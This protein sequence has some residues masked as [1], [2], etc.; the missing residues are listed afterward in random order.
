MEKKHRSIPRCRAR[1]SRWERRASGAGRRAFSE[2]ARCAAPTPEYQLGSLLY[3]GN[4]LVSECIPLGRVNK[5]FSLQ[6]D[7]LARRKWRAHPPHRV[8]PPRKGG[9]EAGQAAEAAGAEVRAQTGEER[10]GVA[11]AIGAGVAAKEG[12]RRRPVREEDAEGKMCQQA[13]KGE[14]GAVAARGEEDAVLPG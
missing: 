2:V 3:Y 11:A 6:L 9:G 4:I 8:H 7:T 5:I 14:G 12:E 13:R 1:W 10:G